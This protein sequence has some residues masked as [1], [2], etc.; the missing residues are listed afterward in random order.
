MYSRL[1]RYLEYV[2][3]NPIA[4]A[5]K[6]QN[7]MAR[8]TQKHILGPAGMNRTMASQWQREKAEVYFDMARGYEYRNARYTKRMRPD[9]HFAGGAG[10]VATVD[11]LAKYDI[12]LDTGRLASSEVMQQLFT[13]PVGPGGK[14]LPYAY[15]WYVQ[16]YLGEKLIWHGGWDE[17]AGFSALYLKVPEQNLTF[18][19]L[20]NS[21][22]MWWGNPLDKAEVE[23]S[24]FAQLFL[25]HFV[26]SPA[27]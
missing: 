25:K 21:E 17:E 12:A 19:V 4:E 9:R 10:V 13:P 1:S 15:G 20:A 18:I 16:E 5:E 3:D 2:H 11:D 6:G 26:S 23:K 8:L 22:G 14:P 24:A 7:T 27:A